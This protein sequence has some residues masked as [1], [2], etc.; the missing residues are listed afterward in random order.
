MAAASRKKPSSRHVHAVYQ[1][2]RLI[3]YVL[4]RR[5]ASYRSS[6]LQPRVTTI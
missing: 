6:A 1:H 2:G 4:L 3:P 5:N